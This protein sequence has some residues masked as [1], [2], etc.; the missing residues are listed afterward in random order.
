[1]FSTPDTITKYS[2]HLEINPHSPTI[3]YQK[4]NQPLLKCLSALS[5][6]VEDLWPSTHFYGSSQAAPSAAH[7]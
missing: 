7:L 6:N 2:F 1:M 5:Y 4:K 3:P